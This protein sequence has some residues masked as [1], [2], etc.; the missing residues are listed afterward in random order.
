MTE[1]TILKPGLTCPRVIG[2]LSVVEIERNSIEVTVSL[3][4][5][6]SFWTIA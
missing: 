1:T 5:Y 2:A 6:G 3:L 4:S